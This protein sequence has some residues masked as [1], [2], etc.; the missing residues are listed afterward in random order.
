MRVYVD[1]SRH[2]VLARN[3]NTFCIG[4]HCHLARRTN[5]NNAVLIDNDG[6]VARGLINSMDAVFD[7]PQVQH[8][9]MVK[10]VLSPHHGKQR[11]VG[12]PVQLERT[13]NTI[14]RSAGVDLSKSPEQFG[15]FLTKDAK[16]WVKLVKSA[17]VTVD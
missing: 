13:P 10:E 6:G 9:G 1:D 3:I 15:N 17:G 14:A 16:F 12:Q 4:W 11:L 2:D 8:L 7:Q 5:R